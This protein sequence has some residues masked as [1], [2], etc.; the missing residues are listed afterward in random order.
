MGPR[1]RFF[2][3]LFFS[4]PHW[5]WKLPASM[6]YLISCITANKCTSIAL[7]SKILPLTTPFWFLWI[8]KD[9]ASCILLYYCCESG[10]GRKD[11]RRC[12]DLVFHG[13][14]KMLLGGWWYSLENFCFA[15]R[16]EQFNVLFS[17]F[18]FLF[19][20]QCFQEHSI[21]LDDCLIVETSLLFEWGVPHSGLSRRRWWVQQAFPYPLRCSEKLRLQNS[22]RGARTDEWECHLCYQLNLALWGKAI[23]KKYFF[24]S[25]NI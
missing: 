10:G 6:G 19:V 7:P 2:L 25:N 23:K 22:L 15:F 3:F 4:P 16:T 24:G 9:V 17:L 5:L 11:R 8:V 20:M 18:P 1:W 14:V 13:H 12:S 21:Y